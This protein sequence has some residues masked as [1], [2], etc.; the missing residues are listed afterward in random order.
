MLHTPGST[1]TILSPDQYMHDPSEISECNH[2]GR[3]DSHGKISFQDSQNRIITEI[4]MRRCKDSLW[5]TTNPILL[6][7]AQKPKLRTKTPARP[8]INSARTATWTTPLSKALQHLELWHQRLGHATPRSLK[9]TQQVVDGILNLP[10]AHPLFCCPFC[11]K[12]KLCKNYGGKKS[13]KEA[14]APGTSFYMDLGFI[15]GPKSLQEVLQDGAVPKDTVLKNHDGFSSYLLIIDA[16]TRY[17][18]VFLLKSEDPPIAIID[19]FL[20]KHGTAR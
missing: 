8:S 20:T 2:N 16:A 14:F 4:D 9:R 5:F 17:I 6:P 11:D 7:N 19:Q 15:R 3:K 18:W 1:G 12:A 10:G 13:T